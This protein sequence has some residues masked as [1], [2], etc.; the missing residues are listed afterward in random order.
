[1]KLRLYVSTYLSD[2]ILLVIIDMNFS[3]SNRRRI[4]VYFTRTRSHRTKLHKAISLIHKDIHNDTKH[5]NIE[6]ALVYR[7]IGS[8]S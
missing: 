3:C 5:F 2:G 1:M 6:H 8:D 7:E 4:N